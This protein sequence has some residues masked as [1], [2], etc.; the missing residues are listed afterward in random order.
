MDSLTKRLLS[1]SGL[2]PSRPLLPP[3]QNLRMVYLKEPF[4]DAEIALHEARLALKRVEANNIPNNRSILYKA[5][6]KLQV[7]ERETFA[8]RYVGNNKPV[9]NGWKK[10]TYNTP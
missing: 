2:D 10:S 1:T 8:R 5:M 6:G 3:V 9:L 7:K 4:G